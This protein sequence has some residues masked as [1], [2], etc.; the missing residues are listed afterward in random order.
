MARYLDANIF[1]RT[2]RA[3][4]P[5]WSPACKRLF[6]EIERGIVDAWTSDLVISEVVFVLERS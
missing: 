5:I 6:D 1:L 3:D 4:H 2:V